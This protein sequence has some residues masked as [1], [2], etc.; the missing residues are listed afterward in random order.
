MVC[1]HRQLSASTTQKPDTDKAY[2]AY[3]LEWGNLNNYLDEFYVH[4]TVH[5]SNTSHINTNEM[6]L[7]FYLVVCNVRGLRMQTTHDITDN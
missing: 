5:L 3:G 2:D 4:G 7:F 6:Q 1:T